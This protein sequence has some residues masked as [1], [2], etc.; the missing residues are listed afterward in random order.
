MTNRKQICFEVQPEVH[1]EVK[2]AAAKRNIS[3]NL[4]LHRLI[5][6]ALAKERK[7]DSKVEK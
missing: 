1:T 2:I 7:Y 3:M 4:W 5:M 6:E